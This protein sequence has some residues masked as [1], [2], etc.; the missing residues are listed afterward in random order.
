MRSSGKNRLEIRQ[1]LTQGAEVWA[2]ITVGRT[3]GEHSP[4]V[5]M[6]RY[7]P[8]VDRICRIARVASVH[9]YAQASMIIRCR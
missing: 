4:G 5:Q 1:A 2:N 7:A 9:A 3:F 8:G 6:G